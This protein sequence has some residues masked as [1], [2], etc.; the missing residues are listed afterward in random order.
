L[1]GKV[2]ILKLIAVAYIAAD[3]PF[4]STYPSHIAEKADANQQMTKVERLKFVGAFVE[5]ASIRGSNL[6]E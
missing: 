5:R 2:S 3:Q 6:G 1:Q 4:A